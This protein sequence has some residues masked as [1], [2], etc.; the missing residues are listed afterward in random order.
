MTVRELIE[1]LQTLPPD[2]PVIYRSCSDYSGMEAREIAVQRAT[3]PLKGSSAI[4]HHNRPGEYRLYN[5]PWE[6]KDK[7]LPEPINAVIFPGN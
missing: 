6:Y 5:G 3:D 7:P 2:F 1:L 4:L